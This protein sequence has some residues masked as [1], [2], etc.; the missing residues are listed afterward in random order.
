MK[1][2]R[3][4]A[5]LP[6]ITL[7]LCVALCLSALGGARSAA[8]DAPDA[9]DA[10]PADVAF[11]E[12]QRDA[13]GW[14]GARVRFT[15]QFQDSPPVWNPY[16]TRFG[17]NDYVGAVGWG[18]DQ[19]LWRA[20]DFGAPCVLVFARRG[21]PAATLLDA[22]RTY[23]RF[24][25]VGRVSQVFLGLPWIELETAE[26]LP[27]ETGEGAVLHAS[28]ALR[29]MEAGDWGRA[30]EDLARAEISNLPPLA[31][32]ELARLRSICEAEREARK[33]P[34]LQLPVR[35]P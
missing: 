31:R 33:L 14:L 21:T 11:G 32:D 23:S 24:E 9:P 5:R 1:A 8:T 26:R 6:L 7:I 30:L 13:S 20:E 15:F 10:A 17:T 3:F 12:L 27:Q 16:L 19:L 22:A 18:D 25:V 34:V 35:Q 29:A 28:R 2:R 4:V